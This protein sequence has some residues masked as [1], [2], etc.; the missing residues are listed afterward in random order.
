M[1]YQEKQRFNQWWLWA[2]MLLVAGIPFYGLYRQLYLGNP[3]GN[4]PLSDTGLII[5]AIFMV[6]FVMFFLIMRLILVI[7]NA[8]VFVHFFPLF[9]RKVDWDKIEQL[10]I[11]NY[12]FVGGW[13]IRLTK[14]FG[15][16]YNISGRWGLLVSMKGGDRFCIGTGRNEELQELIKSIDLK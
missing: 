16:V 4:K 13:G 2:I 5:F 12:G 11:V 1:T 15:T 14:Q 7:D 10:E 6:A 9:K 8:G 3:F